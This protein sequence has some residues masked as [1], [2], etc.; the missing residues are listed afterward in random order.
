VPQATLDFLLDPKNILVLDAVL[1]YHVASGA[2]HAADL[3][4]GE[5]IPTA[6]GSEVVVTIKGT[7]VFI[8]NAQV[9][10]PDIGASNGVVHVIDEVLDPNGVF[11]SIVQLAVATP[12]LSTLVTALIAGKLVDTLSGAGP[13]TVFAPTNEAFA[14]VP[15]A[16]LDFL[17]DPKNILVL[18]AVLTYHVASGAVHAADLK[19]GEMIPTAE[20]SEVVVTIK[21]TSVFINNAQVT[22]ADIDASNGVVHIID[23][24]LFPKTGLVTKSPNSL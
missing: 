8:N 18:D 19:D 15:Q 12:E 20:G 22:T 23:E 16:T 6:E 7:S 2:V 14:K 3:K 21:G 4:D 11:G 1:T 5:M 13:F 17:L 24:V 9:T 10:T